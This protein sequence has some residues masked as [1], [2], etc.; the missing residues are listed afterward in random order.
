MA[1]RNFIEALKNTGEAKYAMFANLTAAQLKRRGKD[2]PLEKN[3][4][5]IGDMVRFTGK[6]RKEL[7]KRGRIV[8]VELHGETLAELESQTGIKSYPYGRKA[9]EVKALPALRGVEGAINLDHAIPEETFREPFAR[10][11]SILAETNEPIKGVTF[12]HPPTP[13]DAVAIA[14][15]VHEQT[16][17]NILSNNYTRVGKDGSLI[18]GRLHPGVHVSVNDPFPPDASNDHVGLLSLAVPQAAL[19]S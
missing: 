15:Q 6:Q 8:Y 19:G 1:F 7:E 4:E 11:L 3:K 10:Q 13:A 17:K 18:V 16:E 5:Q 9:E 2:V 14:L 12:I